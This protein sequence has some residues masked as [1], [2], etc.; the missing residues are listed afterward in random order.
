MDPQA[1]PRNRENINAAV[2]A[3]TLHEHQRGYSLLI[4]C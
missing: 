4:T 2:Q 1:L 3:G